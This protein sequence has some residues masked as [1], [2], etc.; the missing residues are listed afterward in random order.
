MYAVAEQLQMPERRGVWLY[1]YDQV[2]HR[3]RMEWIGSLVIGL[4]FLIL[5]VPFGISMWQIST[6]SGLIGRAAAMVLPLAFVAVALVEFPAALIYFYRKSRCIPVD[7]WDCETPHDPAV[8]EH[9][10]QHK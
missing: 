9:H 8:Q 7:I 4:F 1:S 5:G 6:D 3:T 10:G 2:K